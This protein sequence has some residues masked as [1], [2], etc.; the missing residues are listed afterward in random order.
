MSVHRGP[1]RAFTLVEMLTVMA[2]ISTLMAILLPAVNHVREVGRRTMCASNMRQFALASNV[3][4]SIHGAFP[5]GQAGCPKA[6]PTNTVGVFPDLAYT[7]NQ[8]CVGPNW[9]AVLLVHLDEKWLSDE[10]N[11]CAAKDNVYSSCNKI[12][13]APIPSYF[14]CPSAPVDMTPPL[15]ADPNKNS[16]L[17]AI[18]GSNYMYK[19]NYAGCWGNEAYYNIAQQPSPLGAKAVS[20]AQKDGV[21]GY[22][23]VQRPLDI[24]TNLPTTTA[25]LFK[26]GHGKGTR[27]DFMTDGVSKTMMISEILGSDSSN[28]SRGAW[29]WGTMGA[30]AF[31][32]QNAPN[33]SGG[34][35]IQ[36][37]N[38][39][40]RGLLQCTTGAPSKDTATARSGHPGGVNVAMCDSSTRF[41]Q[42]DID[43]DVWKAAATKSGK[44]DDEMG[45]PL[46]PPF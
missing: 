9:M 40:E 22:V 10:L 8:D 35:Q 39:L 28:D 7:V 5:C 11:T 24:V 37:C 15:P 27:I 26:M 13:K 16:F 17:F 20:A 2:I 6:P 43:P 21:F 32:A 14:V 38:T 42:D 31:T 34:D 18:Q 46:P 45:S 44:A 19:G 29:F 36:R 12:I 4:H 3:Y 30:S 33:S 25:G 1:S 23:Y 41:I